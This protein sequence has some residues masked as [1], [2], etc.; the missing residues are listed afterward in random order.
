[1]PPG[2]LQGHLFSQL[3]EGTEGS[4]HELGKA[5]SLLLTASSALPGVSLTRSRF[6]RVAPYMGLEGSFRCYIFSLQRAQRPQQG[7]QT[8]RANELQLDGPVPKTGPT[9]SLQLPAT[10]THNP[11]IQ[12]HNAETKP[13]GS[14][15]SSGLCWFLSFLVF[16]EAC[17]IHPYRNQEAFAYE[18]NRAPT[19]RPM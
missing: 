3:K 12:S 11:Y 1:M 18:R 8:K 17:C 13:L 7:K 5:G 4:G 6:R 14:W 16:A 19:G 2:G 10:G 9:P 15:N